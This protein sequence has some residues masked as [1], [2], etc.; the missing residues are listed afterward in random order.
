MA[1]CKH[2]HTNGSEQNG[3]VEPVD[4]GALVGEKR[5]RV[6]AVRLAARGHPALAPLHEARGQAARLGCRRPRSLP[7]AWKAVR[8]P[9]AEPGGLR[10]GLRGRRAETETESW[11][12]DRALRKFFRLLKDLRGLELRGL[13]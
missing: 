10:A 7:A 12:V 13:Y 11:L 8:Q 3:V 4:K 6:P 2:A 1:E 9:G 5:L